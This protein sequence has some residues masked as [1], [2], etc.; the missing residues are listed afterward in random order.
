MCVTKPKVASLT[1]DAKILAPT[2]MMLIHW[3]D[4]NCMQFSDGGSA[5]CDAFRRQ[6]IIWWCSAVG[7]SF[8]HVRLPWQLL[9]RRIEKWGY[10]QVAPRPHMLLE[11]APFSRTHHCQQLRSSSNFCMARSFCKTPTTKSSTCTDTTEFYS[12][13]SCRVHTQGSIL[14]AP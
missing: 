12:P 9:T 11:G 8:D 6:K 10:L 14:M 4:R 13:C 7:P 2:E 3:E 5:C 1:K